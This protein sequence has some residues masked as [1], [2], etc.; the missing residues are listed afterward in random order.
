MPTRPTGG[1]LAGRCPTLASQVSQTAL[2]ELA[3][4]MADMM[5]VSEEEARL[6]AER[7]L[8]AHKSREH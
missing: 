1:W 6:E 5:K 8:E 3:R 2:D 4:V 7:A